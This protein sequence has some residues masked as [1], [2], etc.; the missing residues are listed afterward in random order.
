[1]RTPRSLAAIA[2]IAALLALPA[3]ARAEFGIVP[4]S[5]TTKAQNEDGT[6][7]AQASSHPY[8]YT[9]SFKLN[10]AA[11][12]TE[13]GELRDVLVNLPP[14]LVGNP[15]A[16]PQC[17][18]QDF[19]GTTP[20]CSPSTQIGIVQVNIPG[21]GLALGALY[22]L[23]PPPGA[24]AQLGFSAGGL[25][26]LQN[27]SVSAA[28]G[29]GVLVS[30]NSIPEEVTSVSETVWGIPADPSHDAQ[31]GLLAAEGSGP[32]V[33]TDAPRLPFLTLPATCVEPLKTTAEVDSKLAP[34]I[35]TRETAYSLDAGAHPTPLSGCESV[36][37]SPS[38]FAT[39]T[40]T[41]AGSSSGLDF[42]LKL[43][44]EGLLNP[45]LLNPEGIV[46]E[47]EPVKTEVA[48]P[49]GITANPAAAAGLGACTPAQFQSASAESAGCPESSKLGTLIASTPLLEEAI[50]GS[51]YLAAPHENPFGSL[52]AL[53]IIARAP[54]HG[55]LIKQAGKVSVDPS[56]GQLTTTFDGLPPLPY[57]SF[58][59]D[60]REGPRA[61]L[62]T[63]ATCGKYVTRAK[64]YPFSAPG[65]PVER[66][67]PF[68]VS[69]GA[70]G[71]ACASSE[72]QL[73][74]HPSL[75]AGTLTPLAGTYSPFV[76]KLSREDGSQQFGSVSTTLPE[77]LVG[78]LA[79]IPSCSDAQIAAAA[80]RSRE[81]EGALEL[82]SPSCPPASQVG[83]VNV[84]AGAGTQPIYVQGK[85][86]LAGPYK[87]APLSL[88]IVTPA[89]AGPFD[90][91]VVVVRTALYVNPETAQIHAISDPIPP[92]LAGI[93][94]DVR[95][96]SLN[97]DRPQFTLNPTDCG[98]MAVLGSAT[99]TLGQ[100]SS[101]SQR[102]QVGACAALGFKPRLALSLEG[103]TKRSDHP[104][105]KSVLTPQA[106][107]ANAGRVAV[108]LPSS[109]FIDQ[110]HINNPC[111]RVQFNA[112]QCPR[113]SVLGTAR[114][115]S[116]LL[117]RPLEGPVY[118]RSNGGE[119][120][121]PDIVVDLK[122]QFEI[123]LVG[124]VDAV[125]HGENS[126]IRT[127]FETIPDA[128]VTKFTLSLY[129]GKRGL[130]VNSTNL[131]AR[132]RRA[133]IRLT[134]QNGRTH[135][136]EPAIANDCGKAKRS[137]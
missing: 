106:G 73:P 132:P 121:L 112:N 68:K 117:D 48:L 6:L 54:E 7:D 26:A 129:G 115:V 136:T 4:G 13:G 128:P 34:G 52:L 81:G 114:A 116:P 25:N 133:T 119:R 131:C 8:S 5:F 71:D 12:H 32:P 104:A 39:P 88:A 85:A 19:E 107:N 127:T 113:N 80:A 16:V 61:P 24:A 76:F 45:G 94:L 79:G 1:M 41:A 53:Y 122:G 124:H 74:N 93:P 21:L 28:G 56:S 70:G 22:N 65:T 14:G 109:E 57:S 67:A 92:M 40:T 50:E 63:P 59:L 83:V 99:S 15:I 27:A 123:I 23:V 43:P 135:N 30:T 95:S 91:G 66:T 35:F 86:Y 111:T 17:S 77:G 47:T 89:I 120:Q 62:I 38:V 126:R 37:F 78:K 44:N 49:A 98:A 130:L 69:S 101:F 9:V 102:F 31:R 18:R 2:A 72:A 137:R 60:L 55:V 20:H 51:V 75:E 134:A 100:V 10:E 90:L 87:G 36:P 108:T 96:V 118:F 42:E 64:L 3:A 97:M 84:G 46:V 33:S 82:S 125:V 29:Y 105:L 11:G 58:E 110:N 103:G